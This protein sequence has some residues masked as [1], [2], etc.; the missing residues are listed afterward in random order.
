VVLALAE[1][2]ALYGVPPLVT[3]F[4]RLFA[5]AYGVLSFLIP[6]Y[7][8]LAALTLLAPSFE[9]RRLF[10]LNCAIF[11]FFTLAVGFSFLRRYEQHAVHA[12]IIAAFSKNGLS[13]TIVAVAMLEWCA[14]VALSR[15]F[16]PA[17]R[18]LERRRSARRYFRRVRASAKEQP[19]EPVTILRLPVFPDLL[20]DASSAGEARSNFLAD[21]L[22]PPSQIEDAVIDTIDLAPSPS[23]PAERMNMLLHNDITPT[24][25]IAASPACSLGASL[26]ALDMK[27][28]A[29]HRKNTALDKGIDNLDNHIAAL[30]AELDKA[31]PKPATA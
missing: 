11:P 7:L 20:E 18:A 15:R 29:L 13:F 16:F 4:G 24:I 6:A 9:P 5:D 28:D 17:E 12:P 10:L 30:H 2:A 14:I 31:L 27:L 8:V 23:E 3:T 19:V 22:T 21:L 1:S 26:D 25:G